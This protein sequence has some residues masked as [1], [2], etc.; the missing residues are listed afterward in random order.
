MRAMYYEAF[1]AV[2]EIRTLPDPTPGEDGEQDSDR[3]LIMP[4][5]LPG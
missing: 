3:Y 1:G 5:R 2:P 4:M